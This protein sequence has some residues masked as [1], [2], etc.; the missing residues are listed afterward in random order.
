MQT[1]VIA[2]PECGTCTEEPM[3]ENACLRCFE[4]PACRVLLRLKT[5][6][7]CVFCSYGDSP[8]PPVIADGR[9]WN[10]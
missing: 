2:C 8:C 6:D 4:C 7:C 10:H 3:P 1:G 9:Q 5:G